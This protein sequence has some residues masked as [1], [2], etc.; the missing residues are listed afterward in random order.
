MSKN[1]N[2]FLLTASLLMIITGCVLIYEK[3]KFPDINQPNQ[4]NQ[5][6]E[7]IPQDHEV[8][9]SLSE[10]NTIVIGPSK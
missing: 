1:L 4:P 8:I 3:N 6:I 10:I 7:A 9:D 2:R 5:T